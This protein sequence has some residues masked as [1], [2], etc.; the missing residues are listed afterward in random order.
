M[1]NLEMIL[2]LHSRRYSVIS[3]VTENVQHRNS[4]RFLHTVVSA[5]EAN[6]MCKLQRNQNW[7]FSGLT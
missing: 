4:L 1:T 5:T 3:L 6:F 7:Y 2:T